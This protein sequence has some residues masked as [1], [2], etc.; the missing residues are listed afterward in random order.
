MKNDF[1]KKRNRSR[2]K[3]ARIFD[4]PPKAHFSLAT[5]L[6]DERGFLCGMI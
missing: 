6:F 2:G 3:V 5:F 4:A 1:G